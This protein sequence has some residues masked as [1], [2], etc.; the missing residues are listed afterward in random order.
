ML[1]LSLVAVAAT[2]TTAAAVV[3]R[4]RRAR[5]GD[6]LARVDFRPAGPAGIHHLAS[7]VSDL[8]DLGIHVHVAGRTGK[9]RLGAILEQ[10]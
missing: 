8:S 7:S 10:R 1:A 9:P 4:R 5:R 3:L 2:A 6:L